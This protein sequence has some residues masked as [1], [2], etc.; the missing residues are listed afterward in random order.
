MRYIIDYAMYSDNDL[1]LISLD[2]EK[3]FDRVEHAYLFDLLKAFGFGDGFISWVNLL[4]NEAECM[5]KIAG[6]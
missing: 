3:A 2:Q 6:G 5:V 4:Y 1:G